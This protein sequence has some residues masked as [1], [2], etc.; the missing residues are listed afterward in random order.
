MERLGLKV[1]IYQVFHLVY[2]IT[3]PLAQQ[4]LQQQL[5]VDRAQQDINEKLGLGLEVL[6]QRQLKIILIKRVVWL[7]E[8]TPIAV[9]LWYHPLLNFG[10]EQL[11]QNLLI[12]AQEKQKVAL[13]EF[14]IVD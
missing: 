12:K 9:M 4:P 6:G 2:L 10:M 3:V 14:L 1:E 13:V 5:A 8:V 11:G 7:L